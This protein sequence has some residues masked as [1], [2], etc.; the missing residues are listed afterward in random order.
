MLISEHVLQ[1][2]SFD[3][4]ELTSLTGKAYNMPSENKLK[5]VSEGTQQAKLQKV[6]VTVRSKDSYFAGEGKSFKRL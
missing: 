5:L 4:K 3:D 1:H 6:H 2:T